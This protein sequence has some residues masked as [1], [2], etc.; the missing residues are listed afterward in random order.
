MWK[1]WNLDTTGMWNLICNSYFASHSWNLL[2]FFDALL[3][4]SCG[5]G[6]LSGTSISGSGGGSCGH[7]RGGTKEDVAD[8]VLTRA[9]SGEL[10]GEMI[11]WKWQ[12]ELLS[13]LY[14]FWTRFFVS[15]RW[16]CKFGF[17]L[18]TAMPLSEIEIDSPID[19]FI[20]N[21]L[22]MYCSAIVL[23]FQPPAILSCWS[24]EPLSAMNVAPVRRQQWAVYFFASSGDFWSHLATST[25]ICDI[26]FIPIGFLVGFP[27]WKYMNNFPVRDSNGN[28]RTYCDTVDL[29]V[30]STIRNEC[31]VFGPFCLSL[32][33]LTNIPLESNFKSSN[34][35]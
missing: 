23:D 33:T 29:N 7:R 34:L 31:V 14:W 27:P 12:L 25:L 24:E 16:G 35:I 20:R 15:S 22:S 32:S 21:D 8:E 26:V 3:P 11:K 18:E 28:F 30:G 17:A 1:H 4:S 2:V 10:G 5:T 13:K 9:G 19:R 6:R